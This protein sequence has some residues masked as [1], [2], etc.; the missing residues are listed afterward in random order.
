LKGNEKMTLAVFG[1]GYWGPNLVRNFTAIGQTVKYVV[2]SSAAQRQKAEKAYPTVT[3]TA[4]A[5]V[6]LNDSDVDAII[7]AI[8]V[9][10]HYEIAK[11]ALLAGKHAL[12][13]KPMTMTGDEADELIEI[14]SKNKLVL[15]S[16]HTFLY[17]G[18]VKKIKALIEAGDLG[19]VLY[20]DSTRVDVGLFQS[21]VNVLWDLAPHDISILSYLI[22][23]KPISVAATGKA[24][25]GASR[26]NIAFLTMNYNIDFIAHANVSWISPVKIR[27]VLIGGTKKMIV[28]DDI[29]PSE[30]VRVYDS[31]F[32]IKDIEEQNKFK[33]DYRMGDVLIPKLDTTEALADMARDFVKAIE[34]GGKHS[35]L[36]DMH[37]GALVVKTLEAAEKSI[38][39]N[40]AE[41]K[42]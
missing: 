1:Y 13:E 24:H 42:L 20:F 31:G 2:D 5:E 30:K 10:Y 36:S 33:V 11:K 37:L 19:D 12:V 32:E 26:E 34:S 18:A 17:T 35:P 39:Q 15:M 27:K 29:E 25:V 3:A 4:D 41:I 23:D 22:N 40:G 38:K 14:A 21:D 7:I 9:R 16:D 6:V 8:P 28:Y